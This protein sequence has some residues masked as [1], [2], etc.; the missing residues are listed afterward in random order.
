MIESAAERNLPEIH[1]LLLGRLGLPVVS[2]NE[3][4]PAMRMRRLL[5]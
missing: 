5:R 3:H 4:R 1:A 2:V